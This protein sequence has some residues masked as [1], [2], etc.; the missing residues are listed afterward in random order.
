MIQRVEIEDQR[1]EP[2]AMEYNSYSFS[3]PKIKNE[4]HGLCWM[5]ELL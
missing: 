3:E 2:R 1:A 5:S 4:E